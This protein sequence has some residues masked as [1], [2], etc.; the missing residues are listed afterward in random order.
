MRVI[1]KY[2]GKLGEIGEING[3]QEMHDFVG[4]F[5]EIVRYHDY[6]IVCNDEFLLNDSPFNCCING[7]MFC[8][9][10]FICSEGIVDEES[11]ERDLISLTD[12]QL[13]SEFIQFLLGNLGKVVL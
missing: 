6:C 3:Y 12:D 8:G 7:T 11:G 4:G 10:I 5:I 1:L 13:E 2:P 9:N